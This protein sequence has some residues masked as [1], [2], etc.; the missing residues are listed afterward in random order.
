MSEYKVT[1]SKDDITFSD[2]DIKRLVNLLRESYESEPFISKVSSTVTQSVLD[3]KS[4]LADTLSQYSS[5]IFKFSLVFL[6]LLF[7]KIGFSAFSSYRAA[8]RRKH[9]KSLKDLYNSIDLLKLTPDMTIVVRCINEKG[10]LKPFMD[11]VD[12]DGLQ[13]VWEIIGDTV[14][15]DEKTIEP[16]FISDLNHNISFIKLPIPI[17]PSKNLMQELQIQLKENHFI[18]TRSPKRGPLRSFS[19]TRIDSSEIDGKLHPELVIS[20]LI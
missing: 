13:K 1:E 6:S 12:D 8:Y 3:I 7:V 9:A 4:Q 20:V 5:N 16:I 19:F 10:Q 15:A 2:E 11:E 18:P 17:D 14:A